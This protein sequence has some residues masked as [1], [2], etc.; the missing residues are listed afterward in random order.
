MVKATTYKYAPDYAIHPGEILEETLDARNIKRRDLAERC[1]LSVKTVSQII[2]GKATIT[3]ETAI[4]LEKVLGVSA[5]I[6]VNLATNYQLHSVKAADRKMLAGEIDWAKKFPLKD[7]RNMGLLEEETDH[8]KI[9]EGLLDFLGVA[10]SKAWEKG[11]QRV[12]VSYR[13]SPAFK[14]SYESLSSWLRISEL[15]AQRIETKPYDKEAFRSA[16]DSIRALTTEEPKVFAPEMRR[17]CSRAGVALVFVPELNKTHLSGTARWLSPNKALISLSLRHKTDDHLWFSFFHEA[18]HIIL[19]GR[20]DVFLDEDGVKPNRY[21][22]EAN[23]FASDFLIPRDDY[24]DFIAEGRVRGN[25]IRIFAGR[26][27]I[28]PGV[29]VGRL[30]HDEHIRFNQHTRLKRG[31]QLVW[32]ASETD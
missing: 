12:A 29:V 19:H 4:Q 18:A 14:S 22:E 21:E 9:V 32:N 3:P 26:I 31:L 13:R 8:G 25:D 30:Q 16:L 28:A 17:L 10:N 11:F 23:Q 7:L 24:E 15:S 5:N 1:Q 27:N 6:W 20:R 2:N